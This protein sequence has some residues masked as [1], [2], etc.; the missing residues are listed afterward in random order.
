MCVRVCVFVCVCC[1]RARV[2]CVCV[3][4]CVFVC[5]VCVRARVC[6]CVLC[7]R[8][9]VVCVSVCLCV[10]LCVYMIIRTCSVMQ[11]CYHKQGV[12]IRKC[13]PDLQVSSELG[14]IITKRFGTGSLLR[15][16]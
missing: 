2:L 12:Y 13:S 16:G 4:L 11:A 5:V 7:A 14:L 3:C 8:S 9:C 15:R 6:L 1:V 10:C